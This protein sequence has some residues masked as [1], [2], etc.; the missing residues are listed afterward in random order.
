MSRESNESMSS[1]RLDDDDDD[2][3]DDDGTI[4]A[5]ISKSYLSLPSIRQILTPGQ[6]GLTCC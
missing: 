2:D 5:C 3:D 1:V 6:H 4:V